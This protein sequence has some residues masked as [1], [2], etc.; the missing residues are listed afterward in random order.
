MRKLESFYEHIFTL[1][2]DEGEAK[3]PFIY[4]ALQESVIEILQSLEIIRGFDYEKYPETYFLKEEIALWIHIYFLLMVK[5]T[6]PPSTVVGGALV[7]M[8][9]GMVMTLCQKFLEERFTLLIDE[10]Q[11]N[12]RLRDMDAYVQRMEFFPFN[13]TSNK[14]FMKC[15]LHFI[16]NDN[17]SNP[18]FL[19]LQYVIVKLLFKVYKTITISWDRPLQLLKFDFEGLSEPI[20]NRVPGNWMA[21]YLSFSIKTD[22]LKE[23]CNIPNMFENA[24]DVA[25]EY[26]VSREKDKLVDVLLTLFA[27]MS[28]DEFFEVYKDSS[29]GSNIHRVISICLLHYMSNDVFKEYV[30]TFSEKLN[31]Y[32]LPYSSKPEPEKKRIN[33]LRYVSIKLQKITSNKIHPIES[34]ES[35]AITESQNPPQ[36]DLFLSQINPKIHVLFSKA[37][38]GENRVF[39]MDTEVNKSI[40]MQKTQD[41]YTELTRCIDRQSNSPETVIKVFKLIFD[42]DV[43]KE[44]VNS[45]SNTTV[46]RTSSTKSGCSK[47]EVVNNSAVDAL[48]I[49]FQNKQFK[50]YFLLGFG[51]VEDCI[52]KHDLHKLYTILMS[53]ELMHHLDYTIISKYIPI[54]EASLYT[55]QYFTTAIHYPGSLI[56]HKLKP[57]QIED[58]LTASCPLY[59]SFVHIVLLSLTFASRYLV[60]YKRFKLG[61]RIEDELVR[62]QQ[63]IENNLKFLSKLLDKFLE[64]L[65]TEDSEKNL[66]IQ[67]LIYL[68][69]RY[70]TLF[71]MYHMTPIRNHIYTINIE[72]KILN[73]CDTYLGYQD[74]VTE[75]MSFPKEQTYNDLLKEGYYLIPE[76]IDQ[77]LKLFIVDP[78]PKLL[79]YNTIN[80]KYDANINADVFEISYLRDVSD[81]EGNTRTEIENVKSDVFIK[82]TRKNKFY[83]TPP[84]KYF[85]ANNSINYFMKQILSDEKYNNVR[86]SK[87][88]GI[89][90]QSFYQKMDL[91]HMYVKMFYGFYSVYNKTSSNKDNVNYIKIRWRKKI[92]T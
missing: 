61:S 64:S 19:M 37:L 85:V 33:L 42:F 62:N 56:K 4:S 9:K 45:R 5:P 69:E 22:K 73:I 57:L 1:V 44:I 41:V 46:T 53:N 40:K 36:L 2:L 81:A 50:T 74:Y 63:E 80:F 90:Y 83:L 65:K 14:F 48:E 49:V 7:Q 67:S 13:R 10:D 29:S 34:S 58:A 89:H 76:T 47:K 31:N 26:I 72:S 32:K 70:T 84:P 3:H 79:S 30:K 11:I 59:G 28:E 52:I 35:T 20:R 71:E 51:I 91:Y 39:L 38:A 8:Y 87:M 15:I 21:Q 92:D 66:Y 27:L 82:R 24:F 16:K 12:A 25:I 17:V 54:G 88:T 77:P 68:F 60:H 18:T 43:L 23:A 86:N 6:S 75:F 78:L 55:L